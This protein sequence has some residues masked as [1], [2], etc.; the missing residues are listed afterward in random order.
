MDD[1]NPASSTIPCDFQLVQPLQQHSQSPC[2][3][4]LVRDWANRD[5][6]T[7]TA[8][9]RKIRGEYYG[10]FLAASYG[11]VHTYYIELDT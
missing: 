2:L 10:A 7:V 3:L 5:E 4:Q 8:Q 9:W 11:D 6:G 1:L